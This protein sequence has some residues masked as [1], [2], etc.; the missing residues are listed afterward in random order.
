MGAFKELLSELIPYTQKVQPK[1]WYFVL[2]AVVVLVLHMVFYRQRY[3]KYIPGIAL[4]LFA[5]Y[6]LIFNGESSIW[7]T[8]PY[9]LSIIILSGAVGLVSIIYAHMLGLLYGK[10]KKRKRPAVGKSSNTKNH[11]TKNNAQNKNDNR[12]EK[13]QMAMS[14]SNDEIKINTKSNELTKT[15]HTK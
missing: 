10:R 11:N 3:V 12:V 2:L 6:K 13:P 9:D 8:S 4:V 15:E 5:L 14:E 7:R 1:L